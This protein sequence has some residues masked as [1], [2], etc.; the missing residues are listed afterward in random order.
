MWK[1]ENREVTAI[2]A[3]QTTGSLCHLDTNSPELPSSDGESAEVTNGE[4]DIPQ[5]GDADLDIEEG[6]FISNRS[7]SD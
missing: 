1:K 5:C 6:G 4:E 2:Q 7:H 3:Y